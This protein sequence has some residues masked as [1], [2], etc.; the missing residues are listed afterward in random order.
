VKIPGARRINIYQNMFSRGPDG[1]IAVSG[2]A[3]QD[4]NTASAFVGLISPDGL[5]QNIIR[6]SPYA[7]HQVTID[8][9]GKIWTSGREIING[10]AVARNY[11]VIR[12]FDINGNV[13]GSSLP[14]AEV[15]TPD[16]LHPT[17][18]A[19]LLSSKDRVGW[20]SSRAGRYIEFSLDGTKIGDYPTL[21]DFSKG[22][23]QAGISTLSGACLCDDGTVFISAYDRTDKGPRNWRLASL[24]RAAGTWNISV[25]SSPWGTLL[26]CEGSDLVVSPKL[27]TVMWLGKQ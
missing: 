5:N 26:G 15:P 12:R 18:G 19:Y 27:P 6:T 25:Q 11:D 13:I 23:P 17:G 3:Y 22:S 10:R 20:Y 8:S 2:S 24:N 16:R 14:L 1:F 4:D 7:A 21:P 9:D